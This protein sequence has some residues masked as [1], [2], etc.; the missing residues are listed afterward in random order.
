M[1]LIN[2][3]EAESPQSTKRPRLLQ[4]QRNTGASPSAVSPASTHVTVAPTSMTQPGIISGDGHASI[5]EEVQMVVDEENSTG[6]HS[7]S[8][9]GIGVEPY[10]CV[11]FAAPRAKLAC[12]EL[13]RES[14]CA[15]KKE[16]ERRGWAFG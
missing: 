5:E 2:N 8:G 13:V 1:T 16:A 15:S 7:R 4:D 6:T 10:L 14:I 9:A 11:G 3:S 12:L